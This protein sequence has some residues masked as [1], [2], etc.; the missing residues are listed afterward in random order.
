M[1]KFKFLII[2]AHRGLRSLSRMKVRKVIFVVNES[3]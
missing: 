3:R 1:S 2:K